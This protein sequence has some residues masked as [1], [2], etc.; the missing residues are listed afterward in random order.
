MKL[1]ALLIAIFVAA[2][3]LAASP[4][5]VHTKHGLD[6]SLGTALCCI[7]A[8]FGFVGLRRANLAWT[9]GLVAWFLLAAAAGQIERRAMPANQ[10]TNLAGTGRLDLGE[11]LRWRGILRADPLRLP[12]GIR[13]D[14]DLEQ[15]Q[16]AGQ[17]RAVHGGLRASYFFNERAPQ[18]PA[19]VRAGE[20]L[21]ILARAR[22]VRNFG[23]PGAFDYRGALRQQAIDLT[24]TLRNPALM[25]ALPGPRPRPAHYVA[26]LRG[27]LLNDLEAMLS[28]AEDRAAIAR[29]M[30]LGDRSFLDSQQADSFR[31]TGAFHVLVVAGL[32][33]G[34]LA[35]FL[36]W[37]GKKLRLPIPARA[38][39]TIAALCFYVAIVEDRPPITR[40]ALMAVIYLLARI[41][42]R[43]VA[44]LNTVSLA[45]ITILLFRPSEISQASFQLSFLAAGIIGAIAE[46]LLQRTTEPYHRAL[47]HLGDVTRDASHAPKAAEFRIDLRSLAAWLR[48]LLPSKVAARSDQ[49]VV[50]PCRVALRL[51]ELAVLSLALQIG[52]L[53]L[54][55]EDFHR[56]SFIAPLANIPAVLLTAIIVPFG[57]ASLVLGAV[58]KYL[59]IALGRVLS[60]LIGML[61]GS[62]HWFAQLP[63]ASTRV[64]SP[65]AAL[66][67]GFFGAALILSAAILTNRRW[68]WRIGLTAV[69]L[70]ASL[71]VIYP[72]SAQFQRGRL[73]VTVLDVGQGDSIFVAFPDGRTMLVDAGGLPGAAYVRGMRPGL[74]VGEDVVSPFLWSRGLKRLDAIVVT[75][76]HEDHL[77]GMPAILRNFR[78]GEL[79]VGRDEDSPAY[80]NVL[81][82]AEMSG[83]PVIHRLRGERFDWAGV[84]M[85][86]LW[87]DSSDPARARNDDSLVLRLEDGQDSFLLTG[88]IERSVERSIL[89]NGDQLASNFL[90]IAHHGGKTS[91]T[92]PFLDAVHPAIAAISV[93]EANPFGHPSPDAIERILAEGT[94]LFRT[95]RDGAVTAATDGRSM[96]VRSFLSC[97]LPCSELSS[98]VASPADTP[99]F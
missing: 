91:S 52:M 65:P 60:L 96:N 32:H 46:P 70:L 76:A 15:V 19:P 89:A 55:A 22:L 53:P 39:L 13:Y 6:V 42:Y 63:W 87:P 7:V 43:R 68:G 17:W 38:L 24:A 27:R 34:V 94:R 85:S 78:V 84:R 2:G 77:G 21:E 20:R 18:N 25:Q 57:F 11:P 29:A 31:E 50:F 82:Q 41:L 35:A 97:E 71:I 33:V 72:F 16:A 58:W 9:A 61:A 4:I 81:A 66:L 10:V 62:M 8:G 54:M 48:S 74:D 86:I 12:W 59:G 49:F 14:I 1:P 47:E 44:L 51:W 69:L 3:V 26:R 90:K 64:P 99:F 79:W 98:S 93:G 45:A 5:A 95:D 23:D 40:A 28:P 67:F 56:V 30:L 83:V 80:R 92:A 37:A 73:E 36:F 75:H 88:D